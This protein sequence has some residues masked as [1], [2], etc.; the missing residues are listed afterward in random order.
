MDLA[1]PAA[2][3]GPWDTLRFLIHLPRLLR[4]YVRL[5]RDPRVSVWPKA[6][7]LGAVGYVILPFDL[8]PDMVPL[9]GQLDD[10]VILVAAAHW[11]M[12]WCPPAV[13]AEHVDALSG[14]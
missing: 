9:L 3:P 8:I 6:M 12:Q 7:L 14:R 2:R 11:F 10:L 4:L 13:V 1:R 5:L